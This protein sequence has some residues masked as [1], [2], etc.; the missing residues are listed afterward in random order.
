[1]IV[2]NEF[3]EIIKNRFDYFEKN[4][5]CKIWC[6][7]WS[8]SRAIGLENKKSDYDIIGI[9]SDNKENDKDKIIGA[10]YENCLCIEYKLY[11]LKYIVDNL[12]KWNR[13]KKIY[14]TII[15]LHDS[16]MVH[17]DL[18]RN[19]IRLSLEHPIFI[20]DAFLQVFKNE[21]ELGL[22]TNDCL[23]YYY[24]R[25]Y[26]NY[27]NFE[28]NEKINIRKYL[29]TL[30]EI[31]AIMWIIENEKLPPTFIELCNRF[32][33]DINLKNKITNL[34]ELNAK[35]TA[36]ENLYTY[37]VDD[38]DKYIKNN[39]INLGEKIYRYSQNN[40]DKKIIERR[41]II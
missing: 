40:L 5:N 19:L 25:A 28:I 16:S 7:G 23:D 18:Y 22:C 41:C 30:Y 34:F 3:F 15:Y 39:L 11:N 14:P 17:E 13:V 33:A 35:G 8:G 38:I 21:I 31:M 32:I 10:I 29:Y 12:I 27:N 9:Y 1:M 24:S 6:Y 26:M 37:R 2:Q 36:K 20:E 4:T